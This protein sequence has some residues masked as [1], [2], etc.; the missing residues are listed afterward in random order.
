[1]YFPSHY[2][3]DGNEWVAKQLYDKLVGL[4]EIA[5]KLSP[6]E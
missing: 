5:A 3:V 6:Q 1:M 4:P 2:T